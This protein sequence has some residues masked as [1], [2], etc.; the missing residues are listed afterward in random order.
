MQCH[1]ILSAAG[2]AAALMIGPAAAQT[3][4]P[5]APPSCYSVYVIAVGAPPESELTIVANGELVGTYNGYAGPHLDP[6]MKPG[7][8]TVSFTYVNPGPNAIAE[9]N[10]KARNGDGRVIF[11]FRPTAKRLS[12]ETKVNFVAEPR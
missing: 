6:Q 10:C 2:L 11:A 5:P 1:Q 12:A 4:Q 3:P 9:L 7:V 8:N